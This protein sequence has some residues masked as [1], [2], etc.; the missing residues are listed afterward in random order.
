[1]AAYESTMRKRKLAFPPRR[2]SKKGSDRRRRNTFPKT[3]ETKR[4]SNFEKREF[5]KGRREGVGPIW[6]TVAI[7]KKLLRL[8]SANSLFLPAR[9]SVGLLL[10]RRSHQVP[11]GE[12]GLQRVKKRHGGGE[13]S[14]SWGEREGKKI[15]GLCTTD[16][17]TMIPNQKRL[18]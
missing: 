15:T 16:D 3:S 13:P 7:G 4:S 5:K 8:L 10:A 11:L 17:Y 2:K 12:T 14:F 6:G 18:F 1:V 9:N